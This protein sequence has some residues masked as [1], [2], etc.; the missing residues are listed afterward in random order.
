METFYFGEPPEFQ[1]CV[2]DGPI[3]M[4]HCP[5]NKKNLGTNPHL[6]N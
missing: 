2:C 4:A 5:K 6:M 3:K 1:V